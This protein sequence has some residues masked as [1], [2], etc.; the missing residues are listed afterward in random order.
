MNRFRLPLS[1]LAVAVLAG[2]ASVEPGS[3]L[4]S[5]QS[6]TK[7]HTGQPLT[8]DRSADELTRTATKVDELLRQPLAIDTAVQIALLNN[9]GLQARFS[10]SASPRPRSCRPAACP[11]R[12]SASAA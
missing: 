11:T 1:L 2:C 9:R 10:S 7:T 3:A 5:V 12:A 8:A 4:S 6:L